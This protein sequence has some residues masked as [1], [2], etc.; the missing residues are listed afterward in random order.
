[1]VMVEI[2]VVIGITMVVR[3]CESGG[4]GGDVVV[5]VRVNV[6]MVV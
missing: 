4:Y 6:A 2:M 3:G 1:M 5:N